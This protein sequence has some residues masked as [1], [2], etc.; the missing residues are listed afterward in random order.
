[1]LQH[2]IG[3]ERHHRGQI[4]LALKLAGQPLSD[5]GGGDVHLDRLRSLK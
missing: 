3:H 1:M 4:R 2:L 5:D